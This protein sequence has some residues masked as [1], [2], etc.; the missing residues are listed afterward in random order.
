MVALKLCFLAS[1]SSVHSFRWI[2]YFAGKGHDI[3]WLYYG[4][5]TQ[6]QIPG[7]RYHQL[8][9]LGFGLIG[10]VQA[11]RN[12]KRIVALTQPDLVHVHSVG[13]YALLALAIKNTPLVVTPWGSDVIYGKNNVFK[14]LVLNAIFKRATLVTCDA[15]HMQKEL[16]ELGVLVSKIKQINFGIDTERFAPSTGDRSFLAQFDVADDSVIISLRNFEPVYDITTLIRAAQIVVQQLP[17]TQFLLVGSGGEE[18]SLK[19][20]VVELALAKSVKFVG[21]VP[22][23]KLPAFLAAADIYVSTSLSDA[24]IAAS[25]AEAMAVGLPVV[26]TNS[27]ENDRWITDGQN[28]LLV[29]V[30]QPALLADRLL[31]LLA[32]TELQKKMGAA[33]RSV[34]VERNNYQVE[35]SKMDHLYRAF[36]GVS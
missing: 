30:S 24:G 33:G 22:N 19:G 28:G 4:E 6:P 35:M 20:L 12:L 10:I 1:A 13:T 31:S 26:I 3:T 29:E 27:G 9:K 15:Y 21:K 16:T 18:A 32:D 34:I 14:R 5:N 2:K 7:V 8:A 17:K 36:Q 25:T 23:D 11:M